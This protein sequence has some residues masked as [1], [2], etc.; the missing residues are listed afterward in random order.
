MARFTASHR[1]RRRLSL[2]LRPHASGGSRSEAP[3]RERG[4]TRRT[5]RLRTRIRHRRAEVAAQ[6]L[7]ACRLHNLR[8]YVFLLGQF[9]QVGRSQWNGP[10]ALASLQQQGPLRRNALWRNHR[11]RARNASRP[12]RILE[13]L[14]AVLRLPSCPLAKGSSQTSEN[15]REVRPTEAQ[16]GGN[17]LASFVPARP[18]ASRVLPRGVSV[19]YLV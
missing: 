9:R 14:Y 12:L 3:S 6:S 13:R 17:R 7:A 18:R 5:P 8:R 2:F 1:P 15:R 19:P 10:P 4:G 16:R 11:R